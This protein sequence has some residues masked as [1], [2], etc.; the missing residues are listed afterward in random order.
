[1]SAQIIQLQTAR[2]KTHDETVW[3]LYPLRVGAREFGLRRK[4]FNNTLRANHW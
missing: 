3:G 4:S 2:E 1:M